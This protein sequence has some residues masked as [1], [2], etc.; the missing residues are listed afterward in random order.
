MRD[1]HKKY[2]YNYSISLSLYLSIYL[3]V[4]FSGS[5]TN[6]VHRSITTVDTFY[7]SFKVKKKTFY[8]SFKKKK[9]R[10][11]LVCACPRGSL[12]T[13]EENQGR[14]RCCCCFGYGAQARASPSV[15]HSLAY[16]SHGYGLIDPSEETDKTRQDIPLSSPWLLI[17][18]APSSA[19]KDPCAL[20]HPSPASPF[21][22]S[23]LF[24]SLA[25]RERSCCHRSVPARKRPH[26]L[27]RRRRRKIMRG[28]SGFRGSSRAP[29]FLYRIM[30]LFPRLHRI[31]L[32]SRGRFEIMVGQQMELHLLL[33]RNR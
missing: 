4:Y 11:F 29:P 7:K 30:H 12:S 1:H 15:S 10:F 22:S 25:R 23:A 26:F 33:L 5:S 21:S 13:K 16:R 3:Y 2:Q 14:N 19:S 20:R 28:R 31:T 6:L 9:K 24:L 27:L 8:K 32:V 17:P 18:S